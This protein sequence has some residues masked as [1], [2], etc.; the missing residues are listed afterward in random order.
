MQPVTKASVT[1]AGN[2]SHAQTMA[3]IPIFDNAYIELSVASFNQLYIAARLQPLG[4]C[5]EVDNFIDLK[6]RHSLTDL[7][8]AIDFYFAM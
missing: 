3:I 5:G 6:Q 7:N 8:Y 4:R 1:A 2:I